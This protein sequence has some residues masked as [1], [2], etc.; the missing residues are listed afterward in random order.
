MKKTA[1]RKALI[2]IP[3]AMFIIAASQIFSQFV[4][5]T[6]ITKGIGIGIGLLLTALIFRNFKAA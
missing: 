6:D 2:L 5:L 4:A 3:I 1:K